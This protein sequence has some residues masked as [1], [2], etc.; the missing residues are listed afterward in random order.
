MKS[1]K[2]A[3]D[4]HSTTLK[5][6]MRRNN[7]AEANFSLFIFHLYDSLFHKHRIDLGF[8]RALHN[9]LRQH[10]LGDL[11]EAGDVGTL[12]IV[13]VVAFLTVLHALLVNALHDLV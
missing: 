6:M 2:F 8:R 5:T 10:G 11:H 12:H 13:D 7:T 9:S 4:T 3:A 1:E